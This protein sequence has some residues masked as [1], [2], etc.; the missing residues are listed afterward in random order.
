[1][2]EKIPTIKAIIE[3]RIIGATILELAIDDISVVNNS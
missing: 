3:E 2:I 1:L